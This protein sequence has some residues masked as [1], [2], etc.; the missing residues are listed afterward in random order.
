[1]NAPLDVAGLDELALRHTP[2]ELLA[3][4]QGGYTFRAPGAGLVHSLVNP[5]AE[6]LRQARQ[7]G[8]TPGS[9]PLLLGCG[10]GWQIRACLELEAA[11]VTV[12]E[13]NPRVLATLARVPE[14]RALLEDARVLLFAPEGD[15]GFLRLV[16][17]ALKHEH[18]S[19][20]LLALASTPAL[21]AEVLPGS[22]G[23]VTD[24]LCRRRNGFA[25]EPTLE[26]NRRMNERFLAT[27]AE[28]R[29]YHGSWGD[30]AVVVCG[31]GPGLDRDLAALAGGRTRLRIVAVNA[32]LAPLLRAGI[33][34]DLVVAVD[35]MNVIQADL[36][37]RAAGIPLLWVP[38]TNHGYVSAWPGPRIL[39]LPA[40]PG[41]KE[42]EWQGL[43]PGTLQTGMG[44]VAGPALDAA[45]RLGT[46]PLYLS[47]VDLGT[48]GGRSYAGAVRRESVS[49]IRS[50][51]GYMRRQLGLFVWELRSRGRRI[52]AFGK[53]PDWLEALPASR[54]LQEME[55]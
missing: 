3:C 24:I 7:A 51:F 38:G 33:T 52:S 21:W 1:M 4:R 54:P 23:L 26:Y 8:V 18:T 20:P 47:G 15:A 50:D 31:A 13:G 32:A 25:Q 28:F 27:S 10:L 43:R 41:L 12:L 29:L 22:R 19:Q 35:G 42:S 39:A 17:Q 34:P 45:R 14:A 16:A 9:R 49:G 2:F 55:A 40:G 6:A 37:A 30:D 36:P 11:Q 46:G 53:S 5:G 44:T 48:P